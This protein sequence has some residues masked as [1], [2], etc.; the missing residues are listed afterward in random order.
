MIRGHTRILLLEDNPADAML[1][2]ATLAEASPDYEVIHVERLSQGLAHLASGAFDLVLADL[3]LPDSQGVGTVKQL[4]AAAPAAPVVV[5]SGLD[6]EDM[7]LQAVQSGAEGYLVKWRFGANLLTR[8]M[9]H[10]IEH[11]QQLAVLEE[12]LRALESWRELFSRAIELVADGVI[13]VDREGTIALTNQSATQ[14]FGRQA[15]ELTGTYVG[16]VDEDN[17]TQVLRSLAAPGAKAATD[18]RVAT[19]EWQGNR[20]S[21]LLFGWEQ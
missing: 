21:L 2:E 18:I 5:L 19:P 13:L 3:S 9:S 6:D 20:W 15:G 17:A 7:A 11:R 16:R 14:A 1:L 10:A 12:R 8:T 4:R